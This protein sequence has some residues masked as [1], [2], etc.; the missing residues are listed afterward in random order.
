MIPS[1][2]GTYG[3]P[4]VDAKAVS[5]ESSQLPANRFDRLAEDTAQT[6]RTIT[7]VVALFPT[8]NV[9]APT[10]V[11]PATVQHRNL[12][13]IGSSQKPAV[14]KTATGRYTITWATSFLD[15]LNFDETLALAFPQAPHGFTSDPLDDIHVRVLTLSSNV[16]TIVVQSP[17][18]TDA[19]LGDNSAVAISVTVG[20]I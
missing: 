11:V 14:A 6:T 1:T 9:A 8:T 16:M 5:N 4:H 2:L 13:G 17:R 15:G 19:D 18:G 7:R 12:W 10:S 20:A 3:G